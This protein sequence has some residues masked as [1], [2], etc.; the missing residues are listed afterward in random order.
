[1]A[2]IAAQ[3]AMFQK[4]EK[5]AEGGDSQVGFWQKCFNYSG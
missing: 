1:M 5:A 2:D 4:V 3:L